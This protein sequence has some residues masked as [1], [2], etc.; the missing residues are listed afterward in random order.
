MKKKILQNPSKDASNKILKTFKIGVNKFR[1]PYFVEEVRAEG[2]KEALAI[3]Y[4]KWR[5]FETIS[6]QPPLFALDS[7]GYSLQRQHETVGRVC[8]CFACKTL[9]HRIDKAAD[10]LRALIGGTGSELVVDRTHS[11][12]HE[13]LSS[14]ASVLEGG[15]HIVAMIGHDVLLI[16]GSLPPIDA[17]SSTRKGDTE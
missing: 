6:V 5:P 8:E 2:I 11:L 17:L 10:K 4:R 14:A 1:T 12:V 15:L 3:T 16:D 7:S 9:A 13:L